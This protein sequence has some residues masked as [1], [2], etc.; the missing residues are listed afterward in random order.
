MC[1]MGSRS[2][3]LGVLSLLFAAAFFFLTAFM[4][5]LPYGDN[6][7]DLIQIGIA[8]GDIILF[9]WAVVLGL[10]GLAL[11]IIGI[12]REPTRWASCIGVA[13]SVLALVLVSLVLWV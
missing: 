7:F 10:I 4:R 2:I 12:F 13:A 3:I 8:L 9:A 11:G 6:D 5:K 1:F